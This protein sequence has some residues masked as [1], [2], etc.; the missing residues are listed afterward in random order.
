MKTICNT[1]EL[2]AEAEQWCIGADLLAVDIETIPYRKRKDRKRFPFIM[3]VVAYSAIRD[4]IINSY[5]F[6]LTRTKDAFSLEHPL[7]EQAIQAIKRINACDTRKTLHNGIY[8]A[9]WFIRYC[10]PLEN[11][12]YDSITLWWAR[13]PDLPKTLSFVC[14]VLLD[15]FRYWKMGRKEEDFTNHTFYAMEDTESTLRATIK[16]LEWC[17][18]DSDMLRNFH[19]AHLRN[20]NALSM[21]LKGMAKD[22]K[23]LEE[24]ETE[25]RE[26]ADK[27]L[28]RLRFI[29]ADPEFNPNSTPA[30]LDL[31]YKLLGAQPR[32]AKGRILKRVTGNAKPSVGAI[33]LRNLKGEHPIIRR[34]VAALQEAQEPAKQI[35]NVLGMEFMND[36]VRTGYD[37]VA[38]TTTRLS[39]RKDAFNFGGNLQNLRKKYRR[40]IRAEKKPTS[41]IL[42]GD[43]SAAD[44]VFISYESEEPKKIE[45]IERGLDTH[46]FN[47]S[48][49][50]FPNWT[51][52]RVVAGKAE[53]LD[54]AR[55]QRNPDY[56]LVTHPITGVRQITK[57][58]T[59]G[60]NYLMA[61]F[62][63]LNTAGRETI[64]AAAK[65]LGHQDA[66]F[67][68]LD[69]LVEFCD[70]LDARYR[71]YYPRFQRAGSGSFYADLS[72]GLRTH[73]SFETIFGYRQRFLAD[74]L[75]DSTLRACAA[76]VGQANTA[77]RV[78]MAMMELDDGIR[79][80]QLRFRDA[81]APDD[82]GPALY[83]NE[84][85]FGVSIRLQ[86]HDSITLVCDA[87][88]SNYKEGVD[89]FFRVMARPVPC[90]GRIIRLGIECDVMIHWGHEA[91]VVKKPE[92]VY[93]WVESSLLSR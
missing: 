60:G 84:R 64:I 5:A 23:M 81:E 3:T 1:L 78:N 83:V 92:D 19:R 87:A 8:D 71:N 72:I 11:Y 58:T 85:E 50:F 69:Q 17:L 51:Y 66:G 77:G 29:I 89:R 55:T 40:F 7:A 36:R 32:N 25:L 82:D 57:K 27:A 39:S 90:K 26:K 21:S 9:A 45:I 42:E 18:H 41:F 68:S 13:Y 80:R 76:T 44:D 46:S 63:L 4:G 28:A 65:H 56:E 74:P 6:Q 86:T 73:N 37:G 79:T 12:A 61:G 52:E 34:V 31:F 2:I 48:E 10:V 24:M 15:D 91:V 16:L 54:A 70:W 59:H 75:D 67:W 53:F 22:E 38:T 88:H 14:S 20:L 30:K 62:T 93:R 47:A 43:F 49:V 33:V 35:S